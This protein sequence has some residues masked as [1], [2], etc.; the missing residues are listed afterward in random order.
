MHRKFF[1][2]GIVNPVQ[3]TLFQPRKIKRRLAKRFARDRACVD[4]TSAHVLRTLNDR[5]ALAKIGSLRPG[6]FPGRAAT[7][8]NQIKIFVRNHSASPSNRQRRAERTANT[9]RNAGTWEDSRVRTRRDKKN[10]GK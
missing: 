3:S 4:A 5:D 2:Q 10:M 8:H 9:R 1:L 6:L 7:N